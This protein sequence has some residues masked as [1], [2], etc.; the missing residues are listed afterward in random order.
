VTPTSAGQR[1]TP[2]KS[3]KTGG[4][5]AGAKQV[6]GRYSP[7]RVMHR[8]GPASEG[9]R[10]S[11]ADLAAVIALGFDP[12]RLTGAW[13]VVQGSDAH[14]VAFG[15]LTACM[16]PLVSFNSPHVGIRFPNAPDGPLCPTCVAWGRFLAMS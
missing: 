1:A 10:P 14:H 4:R 8:I 5:D 6:Q 2:G 3:V 9:E 11:A 15:F 16:Q 7:E 13:T 12:P